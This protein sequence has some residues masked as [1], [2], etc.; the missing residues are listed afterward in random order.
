MLSAGISGLVIRP[1]CRGVAAAAVPAVATYA[2]GYVADCAVG[3]IGRCV[4]RVRGRI[5]LVV[6]SRGT[7]VVI[8]GALT[9]VDSAKKYEIVDGRLREIPEDVDVNW[10]V[11]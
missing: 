2:G 4:N 6:Q 8:D 1:L 10:T 9:P 3:M 7:Y 5:T 11:L